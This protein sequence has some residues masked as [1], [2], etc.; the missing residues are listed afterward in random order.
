MTGEPVR[1]RIVDAADDLYY[2]RGITAVGMDEIR[3]TAG[4]SLRKLYLEF[5]SKDDLVLAVLDRRHRMWTDGVAG[6]VATVDDPEEKLLAI[7]DYLADWFADDSFRGCGFINAFGELGGGHPDVVA[8]ARKHKQSF[9]EYVARLVE[10]AGA[11]PSL[12]PQLAILAEGAQTT[13]AIAGTADAA[14]QARDAARI[15]VRAARSADRG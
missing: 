1:D 5:P 12:A 10:E 14:E 7:Y 15:L 8:A 6:R 4:V 13:A 2:A 9:Q 3:D 11:S